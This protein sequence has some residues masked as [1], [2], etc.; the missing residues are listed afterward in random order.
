MAITVGTDTYATLAEADA[1][2][3]ARGWTDWAALTDAAKELRLTDAAVYLDT[4]YTWK[5]IVASTAQPMAWPRGGVI[6]NEGREI[7]SNV[8]P[9]RLKHAQIELARLA[10]EALV[11]TDTQGEVSS[12]TAGSVS[13]TF[14][15]GQTVNEA[16][17]Y[18]PIDRLLTGLYVSRAGLVRNVKLGKA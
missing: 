7:P 2:G 17:K 9:T 4:S 15:D 8:Y 12:L 3:A 14:K 5:G 11:A 13:V 6:D 1:Y 16:A 10:S 18:R